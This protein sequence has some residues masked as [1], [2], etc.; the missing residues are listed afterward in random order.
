MLEQVPDLDAVLIAVSG[1]GLS[2]GIAVAVK[3]IKPDCK[4]Y[5]VTP[6]GNVCLLDLYCRFI[7]IVFPFLLK[8][9]RYIMT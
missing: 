3:S 9:A 5:T 7:F 4:V 2:S 6:K 8:N 1:G